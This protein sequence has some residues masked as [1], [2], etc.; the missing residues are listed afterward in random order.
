[1]VKVIS[2]LLGSAERIAS[3]GPFRPMN[4]GERYERAS[5]E[6]RQSIFERDFDNGIAARRYGTKN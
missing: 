5:R 6:F 2:W 3:I 4:P 1:M